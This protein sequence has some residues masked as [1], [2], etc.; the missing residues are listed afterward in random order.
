MVLEISS[1]MPLCYKLTTH[2]SARTQTFASA[3]LISM[4]TCLQESICNLKYVKLIATRFQILEILSSMTNDMDFISIEKEYIFLKIV[5]AVLGRG[6]MT[7]CF[8][9]PGTLSPLSIVGSFN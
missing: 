8:P 7:L 6:L 9:M 1:A 4:F 3:S 5:S 2:S